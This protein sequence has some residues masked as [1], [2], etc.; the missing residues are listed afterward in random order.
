M[1]LDLQDDKGTCAK[2]NLKIIEVNTFKI[3]DLNVCGG[4]F[5]ITGRTALHLSANQGHSECCENLIIQ[6]ATIMVHDNTCKNTPIHS[7]GTIQFVI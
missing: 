3:S 6:G 7:A 2:E 5:I 4:Q 1:N